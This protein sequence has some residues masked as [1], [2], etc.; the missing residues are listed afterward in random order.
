[1]SIGHFTTYLEST[2]H[3]GTSLREFIQH[4]LKTLKSKGSEATFLETERVLAEIRSAIVSPVTEKPFEE[5]TN[6]QKT[7]NGI[8]SESTL[9]A[10]EEE[11][12]IDLE[13]LHRDHLEGFFHQLFYDVK[14]T[15][16]ENLDKAFLR[17]SSNTEDSARFP[18]Q[19]L[20]VSVVVSLT[21]L[22]EFR[23]GVIEFWSYLYNFRS[24]T[25]RDHYGIDEDTVGMGGVFSKYF[26][27]ERILAS[28]VAVARPEPNAR[29]MNRVPDIFL[30]SFPH[31]HGLSVTSPTSGR[32]PETVEL[33]GSGDEISLRN[34]KHSSEMPTGQFVLRREEYA[35]L[36]EEVYK[37][38][39][40]WPFK[41]PGFQLDIEWIVVS[42]P[43]TETGRRLIL[44][45]LREIPTPI[46]N[47]KESG[48]GSAVFIG[49]HDQKLEMEA[50]EDSDPFLQMFVAGNQVKLSLDAFELRDDLSKDAIR[51]QIDWKGRTGEPLAIDLAKAPKSLH[52]SDWK[53]GEVRPPFKT[54]DSR[55]LSLTI[56]L[57]LPN[58]ANTK[59]YLTL[60]QTR[61][62][63]A[64]VP[65]VLLVT[66]K[67]FRMQ[68]TTPFEAI[69]PKG[70]PDQFISKHF[71]NEPTKTADRIQGWE[72]KLAPENPWFRPPYEVSE[73]FEFLE[74]ELRGVKIDTSSLT[75][76]GGFDKTPQFE[77]QKT[78]LKWNYQNIELSHYN[79]FGAVF[80]PSHHTFHYTYGFDLKHFR[81]AED[82]IAKLGGSFIIFNFPELP[83]G[84]KAY[85]LKHDGTTAP[86]G[87]ILHLRTNERGRNI[88]MG[89][90]HGMHNPRETE[91]NFV[92]PPLPDL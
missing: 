50:F 57:A 85:I 43:S 59:L 81:N 4:S 51:G 61:D 17:S 91:Y 25:L 54:K 77:I 7:A 52:L 37:H 16:G 21:S 70:T 41:R 82:L 55:K 19:G 3:K 2:N 56:D 36:S 84:V 11:P 72:V 30:T 29:W 71:D 48:T 46:Q 13:E 23:K 64:T 88:D 38:F 14:R 22:E 42:D 92:L 27:S 12:D 35:A 49:L 62:I 47:L 86:L 24:Y 39:R 76:F 90:P 32:I 80:A 63:G 73:S 1:M 9:E 44:T 67:D 68:M 18:S 6:E 33:S 78:R 53:K 26:E 74:G 15:V 60:E 34:E 87:S 75:Y 45:E 5:S 69:Y 58:A 83:T 79:P 31:D 66:A 65:D 89:W 10:G 28:G 40:A 8:Q 20:Y